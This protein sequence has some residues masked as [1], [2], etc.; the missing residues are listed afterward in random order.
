M[1]TSFVLPV[2]LEAAAPPVRRDDVRLLVATP[3]G[4]AHA[5]FA[6]IGEYLA[7]G[8]L[9]VVNTSATVPA[10]VDA[11]R[12]NGVPAAV[13]FSTA[14]GESDW[15]VEVRPAG[16][17]S[18]PV[19]DA[20]LGERIR[21]PH[22][23]HLRLIAPYPSGQVR[24]RLWLA[25]VEV[26]GGVLAYLVR[27]GRPIRYAY[28]PRAYP[29]EDYQTVFARDPGSAE[30]PSAGRPFTADIVTDLVSRG[31]TV[32]PVMLHTGVSSQ[33]AGQAPLPEPFRVPE[34]TARLVRLTRASGGRVV[35]VGT[36]VTRALES[37]ADDAGR[38]S[39]RDGWTDLRLGPD[40]PARVV[41]GHRHRVARARSVPSRSATGCGGR[42]PR[43]DRVRRG[44]A[45]ALPVARV[46]R[47]LPAAA[48][49]RPSRRWRRAGRRAAGRCWPPRC[50]AARRPRR[51]AH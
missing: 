6:A 1:T 12:A 17:A 7:P 20:A 48:V 30:M 8:D 26:E 24:P 16:R 9:L 22:G 5:R 37:V 49:A 28:V 15:L 51:R 11:V 25:H 34:P 46:R 50:P 39:A 47:Q 3:A 45:R 31:V 2:G 21:L 38:V 10:A 23:V 29:I 44:A 40:R 41:D 27:V 4:L 43:R 14:V 35:A 33:D 18:G 13:H 36:T 19:D 32:A 42:G